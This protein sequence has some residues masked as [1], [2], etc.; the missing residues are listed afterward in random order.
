MVLYYR[1]CSMVRTRIPQ[2]LL[3]LPE[4]LTGAKGVGDDEAFAEL[5]AWVE[6]EFT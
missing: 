6:L 1:D 4:I 3:G 5:R 2:R